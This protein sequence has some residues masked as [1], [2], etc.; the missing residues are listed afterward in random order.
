MTQEQALEV[1]S[2][3]EQCRGAIP[4]HLVDRIHSYYISYILPGSAKPCTCAPGPWNDMLMALKNKVEETLASY[5][6]KNSTSESG[7]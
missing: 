2:I 5:E 3:L 4:A 7:G 1:K 6:A